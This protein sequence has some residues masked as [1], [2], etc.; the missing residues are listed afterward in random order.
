MKVLIEE[1]EMY[2][3]NHIVSHFPIYRVRKFFYKKAGMTIGD[4]SRLLLGIYIQHPKGITI[5]NNCCIN[6]YCML[7]GRGGLFIGN[8]VSISMYTKVLTGT[9]DSHSDI[10][11]YKSEPVEIKD[12]VWTGINSII[13]PGT[14]LPKGVIIA[15]GSVAIKNVDYE[16]RGIYSG[17]PAKKIGSRKT[18]CDYQLIN[19]KPRF[20]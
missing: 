17:I 11:A 15:A 2:F 4:N 8:N 6:E 16:E 19:W 5:G 13:M 1:L 20:R 9:H 18:E 3:I 12:N 7:D 14:N 10:F